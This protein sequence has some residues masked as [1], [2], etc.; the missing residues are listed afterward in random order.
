MSENGLSSL[1][2]SIDARL[3]LSSR[4]NVLSSRAERGDLVLCPNERSVA[5]S[6]VRGWRKEKREIA[7][8]A[9]LY[10]SSRGTKRSRLSGAC[11]QKKERLLH[12]FA[13]I[14]HREERSDLAFPLSA[15]G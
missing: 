3:G 7:S 9:R 11:V 15:N 6:I 14:C 2:S 12:R 13:S 4:A 5:I 10:L 8:L 1:K